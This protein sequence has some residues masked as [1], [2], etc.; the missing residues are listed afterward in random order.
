M[1]RGG[2]APWET[3]ENQEKIDEETP[4][5]LNQAVEP[6]G[7]A[8]FLHRL[9][10]A[11][12][13][14]VA[15][16]VETQAGAPQHREMVERLLSCLERVTCRAVP[17]G[18]CW[19]GE[20]AKIFD[21]FQCRRANSTQMVRATQQA[22]DLSGDAILVLLND[23][24][25]ALFEPYQKPRRILFRRRSGPTARESFLSI[26]TARIGALLS[27][28]EPDPGSFYSKV[29]DALA[30]CDESQATRPTRR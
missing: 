1:F 27:A 11:E 4:P 5:E 22:S 7:A 14:A 16:K 17:S 21:A 12:R 10:N 24:G 28:L 20:K 25:A 9:F 3:R 15:D 29:R 8:A 19:L 26:D 18:F 30:D 13:S 2:A 23:G 6:G